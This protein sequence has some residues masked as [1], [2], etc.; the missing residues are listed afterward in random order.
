MSTITHDVIVIGAGPAGISAAVTSASQGLKTLLVDEQPRPGGQIYRNITAV[1]PAVAALLGPD[2]RH[3]ATLAERLAGSGVEVQFGATVWDVAQDLT[4]TVQKD[5]ASFQ[6]RAPQ[7]IAATGAMERASPVPGWTLPGVLNAGAAQIA[8]KS[9][10][11]VPSGRVVLAGAGPLLL[12]V[13]CQLLDAGVILAGIIE[14]APSANRWRALRHL[15]GA[16]GAMPYLLKGMRMLRRLRR[17]GVPMYAAVDTLRIEG[18]ECVQGVSFNAAGT[19][20]RLEADVVLLHHGVVPNTQ[21]S[22]LLRVDHAWDADQLAWR[23]RTDAWGQTSLAGLRIVGDGAGI[24]G[25]L[26]AEPSGSIAALGAAEALGRITADACR[27]QVAPMRRALQKQLRIRPFLDALYRPPQWLATPAD[28]TIVCRCEEVSAGRIRE[29][30]QL[31]C[32]G[33]NQTK[34][35][36]RC[37]MGPCQGRMCALTVTQILSVELGKAPEEIGTYHIRSPLKPVPLGSLAA[38]A[39]QEEEEI[40]EH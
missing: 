2:Y 19:L 12:L 3:G 34:F 8:L 32:Q 4:V 25:A 5:G 28:E 16:L 7:L 29:M 23:A 9:A 21:L 11:S 35:F 10:G 14:T 36:S 33:P 15:P 1:S 30:A 20:R 37:G 40:H 26:A 13:A 22:R 17:D 6:A 31:G 27:S 38:L 18:R 39:N 24:A